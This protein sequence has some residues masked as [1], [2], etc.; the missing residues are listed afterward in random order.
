[1]PSSWQP[2]HALRCSESYDRRTNG[3]LVS[4]SRAIGGTTATAIFRTRSDRSNS[5]TSVGIDSHA[6]T[7]TATHGLLETS[8]TT[9]PSCQRVRSRPIQ[10]MTNAMARGSACARV[11]G[12]WFFFFA[13]Q[14]TATVL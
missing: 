7:S 13:L 4:C 8:P 3:R 14:E 12:A 11:Q 5:P 10:E 1:M 9:S 6:W 2:G